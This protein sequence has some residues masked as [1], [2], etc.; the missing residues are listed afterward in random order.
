MFFDEED[1]QLDNLQILSV[2]MARRRLQVTEYLDTS[3]GEI[4]TATEVCKFGVREIRSDARVRREAVLA[5]LRK[6]VREFADFVLRFRNGR[7]SFSPGMDQLV[8]WYAYLH[9]KRPDNVRRIVKGLI[10]GGVVERTAHGE[11][12]PT[13]D[14]RWHQRGSLKALIDG[15]YSAALLKFDRLLLARNYA[16][17]RYR[18]AREQEERSAERQAA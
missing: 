2:H 10:K 14:F 16:I 9:D 15:E 1:S 17:A 5:S 13:A 8:L 12:I 11:Y 3:T 6:E 4:L 18:C 7:C